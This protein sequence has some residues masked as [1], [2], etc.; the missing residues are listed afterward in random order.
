MFWKG[1]VNP[2]PEF[3]LRIN[4][5]DKSRKFKYHFYTNYVFNFDSSELQSYLVFRDV[6][7]RNEQET[8]FIWFTKGKYGFSLRQCSQIIL[9]VDFDV[10]YKFLYK[11]NVLRNG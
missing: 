6:Q 5:M 11:E 2:F 8:Y 4:I 10:I 7:L 1:G 3:Y 9:S